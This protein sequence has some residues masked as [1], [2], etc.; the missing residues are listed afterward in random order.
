M[1]RQAEGAEDVTYTIEERSSTAPSSTQPRPA[2][3]S[4][5]HKAIDVVTSELRAVE[6]S[7]AADVAEVKVELE[8][9]KTH[10][11]AKEV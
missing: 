7:A 4:S 3:L 5:A 11:A 2:A 1:A 10:T 9:M 8:R 6:V